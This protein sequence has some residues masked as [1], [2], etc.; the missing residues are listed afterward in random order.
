M[1]VENVRGHNNNNNNNS[2][3]NKKNDDVNRNE[4]ENTRTNCQ[5]MNRWTSVIW[6]DCDLLAPTRYIINDEI[7]LCSLYWDTFVCFINCDFNKITVHK[8]IAPPNQTRVL[9]YVILINNIDIKRPMWYV[10][11][12]RDFA[13]MAK[14]TGK[15]DV[16]CH[17]SGCLSVCL[18]RETYIQMY[19]CFVFFF[20]NR[21]KHIYRNVNV[22]VCCDA[23]I[24]CLQKTIEWDKKMNTC[25]SNFTRH[26][27]G[28]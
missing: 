12:I 9:H 2:S 14:I 17:I 22:N 24:M 16:S 7:Q 5:W 21:H 15:I 10:F 18:N 6:I 27:G 19:M 28:C 1:P 4:Q 11:V 26:I 8:N 23:A 13:K 20:F 3:S 25:F